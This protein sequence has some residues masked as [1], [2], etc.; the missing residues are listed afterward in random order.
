[1]DRKEASERIKKLREKI[2]KLNYQY[3][4]LD[5]SEVSE[6]VRDSLKKEL[7]A[8]EAE[9]PDLITKDSPTQRVG[10]VL[11][12][13]FAKV[14]HVTPKKSL[15]DVFSAQEIR[16][17]NDRIQKLVPGEKI[18][19]ICEL[20]I[21][22]LNITIHYESG[23]FKRALTRGNG[24]TGED[25]TH[26]VK[27]IESVPLSLDEKIDLEVS[28][29][30]FLSKKAF[31]KMGDEFANP[32]NAAAG[33]IR[34][35]DPNVAAERKLEVYF[36]EI[37]KNS[38]QKKPQTQKECLKTLKA[39][40]LRTNLQTKKMSSIE[41]VIKHCEDW[42]ERRKKQKYEIDGIVIKVNSISQ[43]KKM[44]YTAKAP[45]FMIAYKFPAEQSTTVIEDIKVQV[46]RT[47]ALTPVAHLRP[48]WVS[49]SQVSRATLHNED[50]IKRKDVRIGDTV[51]VQKAGDVIPEVVEVL[52]DL[53]TGKEK[54]FHF[55][56]KCPVCGSNVVRQEG[57][58]AYRCGNQGCAGAAERGLIHFVSRP[59]F[60]I[61]SLGEKIII[62]LL[63]FDLIK[64][65]ADIFCLTKEDFLN[66]PLFQEKR[67]QNVYDAIQKAKN[68][69][70]PRFLFSLGIRY[71]GEQGS[72]D[73]AQYMDSDGKIQIPDIVEKLKSLSTSG[74]QMING[75]GEKVAQS[76]YDWFHNRGNEELLKKLQKSGV[77]ILGQSGTKKTLEGK[78]FV[79]TG[80]LENFGREEIKTVIREHGGDVQSLV[81]AKTDFL[82]CGENPGSKYEKAKELGVK[83]IDE[84]EFVKMLG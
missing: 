16:D 7:V 6:A 46:G 78:S 76:I 67:A 39:L 42:H 11:S 80:T 18:E 50:E 44:G 29:E 23:E 14:D 84:K 60:N 28:G 10:S 58:V 47:G 33:T 12:G 5:K 69:S 32:R 53:R 45:R 54:I 74:L 62:E 9:F 61:D 64:D 36:Y 70:L 43:H 35:L 72:F 59:A 15:A 48:V 79:V 31:L 22:G 51:I 65:P 40:G 34:Q 81:S 25:V 71:L 38:L 3:F 83:I 20:K 49:G 19:Y 68:V 66:L 26:T 30:V 17:W 1:M 37:G 4:V 57:E 63:E 8:L 41:E 52:K 77:T 24:I 73:L 27:T 13:R 56:K 2:K 55:P 75:V 82:L 21:D